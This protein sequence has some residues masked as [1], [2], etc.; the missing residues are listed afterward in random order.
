VV[1]L[2][3]ILVATDFGEAAAVALNYGRA[4][5][6]QQDRTTL[7]AKAIVPEAL[8]GVARAR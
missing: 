8:V 5:L 3:R 2:K 7:K 4:L 1:A 6:D